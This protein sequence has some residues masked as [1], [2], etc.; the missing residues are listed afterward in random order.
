MKTTKI[1]KQQPIAKPNP[2]KPTTMKLTLLLSA[3]LGASLANGHA[4]AM[5]PIAATGWNQDVVIGSG[6]TI[7]G[8]TATMDGGNLGFTWYGVGFNAA[9]PTTGL[10]TG[11]TT[12]E[13]TPTDLSFQLQP[14][15]TLAGG[16]V[17]NAIFQG[18]TL[19]MTT[20]MPYIRLALIGST[21]GGSSN[22]TVT[23]NY[24][25]GPAQ[26]FGFNNAGVARDWFGGAPTAFTAA[27]R[28]RV[29]DE[30]FNAVGSGEPR[31]YQSVFTLNN[32]VGNVTSV[33]ITATGNNAVMAISGEAI[34]E[35]SSFA[36]LGFSA[37][38]FALRRRR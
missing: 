28:I 30:V 21:G 23:V 24:S 20:P 11:L 5:L 25:S 31:L 34:P 8:R 18:G 13:D 38:G 35:V 1:M 15:G 19:T 3:A 32:N 27:G 14:F 37:I 9:A 12:S 2:M 26:V 33:V 4:A 22:M 10:P 29:D 16:N 7:A 6:D 17:N 36:L